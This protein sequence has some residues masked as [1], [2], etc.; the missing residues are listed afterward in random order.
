MAF[1]HGAEVIETS[2]GVRPINEARSAVIGLVGTAPK[3]PTNALTVIST[4]RQAVETFGE[5][6]PGF[7]IPAALDS[8]FAQ[9]GARVIVVNVFD[10]A[11][12]TTAVAD[13]S[14]T[15][16]AGKI[17]LDFAPV[18]N[19][20]VTNSAGTT[21]YDA[22]THYEVNAF[23][24]VRILDT[25]TIP[26]GTEL[27]IDYVYLDGTAITGTV[28]NGS[29]TL[30]RTGIELLDE[31]ASTF[32]YTP[33]I[34]ISPLYN[35]VAAVATKL[36]AKAESYR[37][38][39]ILDAPVATTIS[40]AIASRGGAST[41][42]PY[43]VSD[44]RVILTYP[45]VKAADQLGATVNRP[46]SPYLAGVMAVTDNTEGYWNSPSNR[47]IKGTLG[48][49][50][51]LTAGISDLNSDV[52]QLNEQGIV[53][54][55][56]AFGT[57][58]RTWGNRS[59]AW[60]IET[61][62]DNFIAVQRVKDILNESVEAAMLPFI[63]RPINQALIDAIRETVNAFIRSLVGR[64]ALVDGVCTYNPADNSPSEIAAGRLV[65]DINFMPPTPAER[66]TF[67]SYLDQ[68][69]L[70]NIA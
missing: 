41:V 32:G 29:A 47:Q 22:G 46:Y 62:A 3:G 61:T 14:Q 59:S 67:K 12:H 43:Q 39:T 60:P 21:T 23:G 27:L 42:L 1:L 44:K 70:A 68:S 50:V 20:V 2:Q 51:M 28:V 53:T 48:P 25:T 40:A 69:L 45:Y 5:Q 57:G 9:G 8:I 37:G 64:G 66:I 26:N 17:T 65:F 49:V 30:P 36:A 55:F 13:E 63:D 16:A 33:R 38:V 35:E 56:N 34:L 18:G 19:I 52:N 31:A 24:V 4:P 15:T 7:T 11:D 10:V 58:F 6:V 54:V